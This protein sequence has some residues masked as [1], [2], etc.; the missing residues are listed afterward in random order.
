[1]KTLKQRI[2]EWKLSDETCSNVRL[3]NA[4]IKP[5]GNALEL[6]IP[7]NNGYRFALHIAED[8]K[9]DAKEDIVM[10]LNK[11]EYHKNKEGYYCYFDDDDSWRWVLLFGDEA[12]SFLNKL[13][14]DNEQTFDVRYLCWSLISKYKTYEFICKDDTNS[15]YTKEEIQDMIEMIK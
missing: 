15:F 10:H 4:N 12:I 8:Y 3:T 13:L 5:E 11:Y 2:N 6:A 1:M 9:Y 7:Y 14:A